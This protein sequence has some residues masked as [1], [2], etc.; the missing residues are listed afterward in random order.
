MIPG[1]MIHLNN[2]CSR[3]KRWASPH[4]WTAMIISFSKALIWW[5]NIR[6]GAGN[7]EWAIGNRQWAMGNCGEP[8]D[9]SRT[10][11]TG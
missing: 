11:N 6:K 10:K 1:T 2:L 3:I 7:G 8:Q 9:F 4:D 5:V